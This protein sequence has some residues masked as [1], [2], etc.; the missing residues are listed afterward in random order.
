MAAPA[1]T[2]A[3]KQQQAAAVAACLAECKTVVADAK[4]GDKLRV[5]KACRDVVQAAGVAASARREAATK[6]T[7]AVG[8]MPIAVSGDVRACAAAYGGLCNV[9]CHAVGEVLVASTPTLG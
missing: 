1:G 5:A 2:T 3:G 9:A 4:V 6:C 7:T 8:A